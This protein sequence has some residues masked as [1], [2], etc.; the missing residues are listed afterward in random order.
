VHTADEDCGG[1]GTVYADGSE[2]DTGL[3]TRAGFRWWVVPLLAI[4]VGLV[5][6]LVYRFVERQLDRRRG[7]ALEARLA[8]GE[9]I[10]LPG[11]RDEADP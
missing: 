6:W 10:P 9:T 11:L 8:S 7:R 4:P 2:I 1:G 5:A 3:F